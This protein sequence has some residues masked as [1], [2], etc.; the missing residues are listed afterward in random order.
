M[1][2][3]AVRI[4][5]VETFVLSN[6]SALVKIS[7][8][9]GVA[10]WGECV[11]E[12][13]ARPSVATVQ[14][15]AEYLIGQDPRRITHLWQLLSR[16]GFY[17]GGPII[18]AAVSGID[19]ALWDIK[20][21]LLDAPIHELLGGPTRDRAQV[22]AHCGYGGG[23]GSPEKARELAA[24]GYRLLKFAPDYGPVEHLDSP[25]WIERFVADVA[26]M[27]DAVGPETGLAIDFH[28]RLSIAQSRRVL[29]LLEPYHLTFVEEPLRPE[30]SDFIGE[31]VH[32]TTIPIAT[33]ERRYQREEF[34]TILEAGVAVV[35]PDTSHAGG[36]SETFRIALLAESYGAALAPHCPLGPI[37]LAACLQV[38]FAVSN[39]LSQEQVIDT[40]L[41]GSATREVLVDPDVLL[42]VDGWIERP[43]GP[44]LGIEVD[45]DVVRSRVVEG[46]L[47]PGSPIWIAADGSFAEW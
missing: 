11:A 18:G 24:A 1:S 4:T 31:V 32:A 8:D 38:D 3:V 2:T 23:A 17:R 13:W 39:F 12:N 40:H 25:A 37:S 27:R 30:H 16:G 42:A 14:R 44:G 5:E 35:Q 20:G 26:A 29:P 7:T 10:G 15:M 6:R 21:R 22:Y 33:G 41:T 46:D 28:G 45:E 36:I 19:Q 47:E 9:A 34:R 43:T